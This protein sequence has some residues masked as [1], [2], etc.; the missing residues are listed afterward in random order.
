[1]RLVLARIASYHEIRTYWDIV[2][3]FEANQ[4]LDIQQDME[5]MQVR[6]AERQMKKRR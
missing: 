3:V 1:M 6:E 5:W 4:L 2:E